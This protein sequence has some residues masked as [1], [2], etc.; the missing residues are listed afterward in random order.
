MMKKLIALC[1]ACLAC[2]FILTA[3]EEQKDEENWRF[4]TGGVTLEPGKTCA[5]ALTKLSSACKSHSATDSCANAAGQD[6]LY[7]YDG[8]RLTTYREKEN[9]PNEKLVKIEF[10]SDAVK[11][12]EGITVG[13]T[14][15]AVKAAYGEPTTDSGS[16][17]IYRRG[18]T[19]LLLTVRDGR[20]TGISYSEA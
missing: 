10:T 20:V 18:A 3:C 14:A 4:T 5:E 13:S 6:V 1:M 9:D 15:D 7:V 11:T 2:L 19:E 16:T 12:A 8:F 17:L